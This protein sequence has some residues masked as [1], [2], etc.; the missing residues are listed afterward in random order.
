ML[1]ARGA[2]T[3]VQAV[4]AHRHPLRAILLQGVVHHL[5]PGD[6]GGADD[7]PGGP[8]LADGDHVQLVFDPAAQLHGQAGFLDHLIN[9]GEIVPHPVPGPVQIHHVDPSGPGGGEG[10]RRLQRA[11]GHLAD[12]GELPFFQTDAPPV[13]HVDGR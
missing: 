8:G 12:G 7:H 2:H 13:L 10:L 4:D 5:R 6:G 1:P 9:Q 11:V 3:P